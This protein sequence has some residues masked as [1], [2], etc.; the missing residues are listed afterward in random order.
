[1]YLLVLQMEDKIKYKILN[2]DKLTF[3]F[4]SN[5][6]SDQTA[7]VDLYLKNWSILSMRGNLF[8]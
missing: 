3:C 4:K 2:F 6:R 5:I 7:Y 1:M 8:L